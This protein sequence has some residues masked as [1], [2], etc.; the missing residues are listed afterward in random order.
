MGDVA[1]DE[2]AEL[3][4][5]G[6][7]IV[8]IPFTDPA[9]LGGEMFRWELATAIA[10]AVIGIQPF[11]QPDVQSAKD[12]TKAAL[13]S[14]E[15]SEPDRGNLAELLGEAGPGNY[16]AIQ[17]YL[18]RDPDNEQRL[19][20]VRMKLR[21]RLRV[22]TTV[23]FGPRFLHSTGQLHKGGPNTG[24][25]VQVVDEPKEDVPIPGKPFTFGR[26]IKAQADG[27]LTALRDRGRRAIRVSLEEL[28]S[29]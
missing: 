16:L 28:E 1:S 13:E 4:G 21:D 25:F 5:A 23:G 26:L 2:L 18:R 9:S 22:A 15:V 27:D 14:D 12:A 19:Q 10:G 20:D 3:E 24:L 11:D 8:R 6:Y 17:A 7:P 29:A